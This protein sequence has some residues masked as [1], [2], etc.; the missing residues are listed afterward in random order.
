MPAPV[1]QNQADEAD[2][3]RVVGKL[4]TTS[5][6][7]VDRLVDALEPVVEGRLSSAPHGKA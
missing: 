4:P 3:W 6:Q 5:P 7:R 2:R 1:D